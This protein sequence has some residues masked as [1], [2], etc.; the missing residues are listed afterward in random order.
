MWP[1]SIVLLIFS[2]VVGV[3]GLV[4]YKDNAIYDRRISGGIVE[5]FNAYDIGT[6]DFA[7]IGKTQVIPDCSQGP[8]MSGVTRIM[9]C[10]MEF[11]RERSG[12][13]WLNVDSWCDD[14][15]GGGCSWGA[16]YSKDGAYVY[17][18]DDGDKKHMLAAYAELYATD[19]GGVIVTGQSQVGFLHKG[20][21]LDPSGKLVTSVPPVT[22]LDGL[23]PEGAL[24]R[25]LKNN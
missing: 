13:R 16:L 7:K 9:A 12:M 3:L 1:I 22:V 18:V 20:E 24:V 2:F 19:A 15:S 11:E 4:A 25:V 14:S 8:S 6:R 21:L 5:M 10:E 17:K 23:V